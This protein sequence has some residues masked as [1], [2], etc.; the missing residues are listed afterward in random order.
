MRLSLIA[1]VSASSPDAVTKFGCGEIGRS[2]NST[3][4]A[5]S[6]L[7][8]RVKATLIVSTFPFSGRSLP[9]HRTLLRRLSPEGHRLA[10]SPAFF[11]EGDER[12]LRSP[13]R[14][15]ARTGEIR[16]KDRPKRDASRVLM[17]KGLDSAV[18]FSLNMRTDLSWNRRISS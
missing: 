18:R 7:S 14:A 5:V 11:N 10:L 13:K 1:L 2:G 15:P 3:S 8:S 6:A 17:V 16:A 12:A 9:R 4:A